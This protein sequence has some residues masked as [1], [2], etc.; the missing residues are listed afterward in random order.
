MKKSVVIS[1][2]VS[3]FFLAGPVLCFANTSDVPDARMEW[4]LNDKF[5][6][7]IHWGPSSIMGVEISWA[8]ET[9]PFDHPGQLEKIPDEVYDALYKE[10]NPVEFDADEMVC[11]AKDAGMKYIVF[12]AKHHDGFSNWHTALSEP[13]PEDNWTGYTGFIHQVA[14]D[15]YLKDHPNPEDIEYYL[16]GPPMMLS[17]VMNLL[18]DLGVEDEMVK[19]DDFG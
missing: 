16:C 13:L 5:G 6:M 7:F 12:T 10:F 15:N 3:L 2:F 17:A 19:F 4:W 8:R 9:H 1:L 18:R 11:A 14:A